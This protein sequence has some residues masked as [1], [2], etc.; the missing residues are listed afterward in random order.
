MIRAN[1]SANFRCQV[2]LANTTPNRSIEDR[3]RLRIHACGAFTFISSGAACARESRR[4]LP[5]VSR[6]EVFAG[7][8]TSFIVTAANVRDITMLSAVLEAI[9]VTRPQPP[10]RRSKHLCAGAGCRSRI[11]QGSSKNTATSLTSSIA[12][13]RRIAG[14]AIQRRSLDVVYIARARSA[15]RKRHVLTI[16]CQAPATPLAHKRQTSA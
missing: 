4:I 14:V 5:N 6:V 7:D 8:Q 15:I 3:Q 16:P 12:D 11:G 10:H 2:F 9:A 1:R 13:R